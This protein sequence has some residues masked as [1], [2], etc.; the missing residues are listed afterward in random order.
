MENN[1]YKK[2]KQQPAFVLS[3]YIIGVIA[4]EILRN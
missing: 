3:Y 2:E 1:K 4:T